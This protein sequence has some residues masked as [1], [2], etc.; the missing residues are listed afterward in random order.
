MI[1]LLDER[2]K[3]GVEVRIIG[4]LSRAGANLTVKKLAQMRLHTRTIIRDGSQAF[5]GSQ[6]LRPLELD[7]RREIGVIFQDLKVVSRL[8]KT[9]QDDWALKEQPVQAVIVKEELPPAAKVAKKVARAVVKD[10]GPVMP[11]MEATVKEVA[12]AA[13]E[14]GLNG[15]EFEE[16]VKDAVKDAVKQVVMNAVEDVAAAQE[17]PKEGAR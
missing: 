10:M 12:G 4:R 1:R 13:T 15:E 3:A 7:A 8:T 5:L 6:S 9:F 2:A 14:A 11:T 16:A 17:S